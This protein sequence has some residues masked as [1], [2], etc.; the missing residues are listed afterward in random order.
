MYNCKSSL[1]FVY[2]NN[3]AHKLSYIAIAIAKLKFVPLV[4]RPSSIISMLYIMNTPPHTNNSDIKR[5]SSD[6][7]SNDI[8]CFSTTTALGGNSNILSSSSSYLNATSASTA[9]AQQQHYQS[10]MTAAYCNDSTSNVQ[11]PINVNNQQ[12]QPQHNMMA[13]MLDNSNRLSSSSSASMTH[14]MNINPYNYTSDMNTYQGIN[15]Y[16]QQAQGQQIHGYDPSIDMQRLLAI[17]KREIELEAEIKKMEQKMSM[18]TSHGGCNDYDNDTSKQASTST[19]ATRGRKRVSSSD[20]E[21]EQV[22]P[23]LTGYAKI[24]EV[25]RRH[26]ADL[27]NYGKKS[28]KRKIDR[29]GSGGSGG[30]SSSVARAA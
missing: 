26:S 28:K 7:N 16:Q 24:V 21:E 17:Q 5:A 27:L 23:L 4:H 22:E 25:E 8:N 14:H 3:Y 10:I 1:P 30:S 6:N 13:T 20:E 9:A 2:Q 11:L 18:S 19:A 12:T 29:R 15:S